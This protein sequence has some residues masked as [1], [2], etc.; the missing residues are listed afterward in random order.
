M[1]C[2]LHIGDQKTGSKSI[3]MF[4][5]QNTAKMSDQNIFLNKSAL[6]GL[7]HSGLCAYAMDELRMK[8]NP[9]REWNIL[10]SKQ[11]A[12]FRKNF[13]A[14]LTDELKHYDSDATIVFSHEGLLWLN[15]QEI[16]RIKDLLSDY[17]D[18]FK[19]IIYL[20]RQDKA[21]LSSYGQ[22][23]KQGIYTKKVF[24]RLVKNFDYLKALND[25]SNVFTRKSMRI[26]VF[27][28]D[29]FVKRDLLQDFAAKCEFV[30]GQLNFA[31]PKNVSLNDKALMFLN[32]I[33][34]FNHFQKDEKFRNHRRLVSL[35]QTNYSGK[36]NFVTKEEAIEYYKKFTSINDGILST[37]FPERDSLFD[38]DF[39]SYAQDSESLYRPSPEDFYEVFYFVLNK[40]MK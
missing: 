17:F 13:I 26:E 35:L 11:V 22:R 8:N 10:R 19:L 3:Q 23:I 30:P 20:R 29:K 31:P 7:Y 21:T 14:K 36:S 12:G 39:D 18:E 1:K 28:R 24:Y 2:I 6:I 33:N 15:R 27:E 38:D 40:L 34:K 32:R 16:S 37:Y 4:L 25:W 5:K 9:R